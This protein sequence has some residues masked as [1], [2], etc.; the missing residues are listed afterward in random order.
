M[1]GTQAFL[2]GQVQFAKPGLE[3]VQTGTGFLTF[4]AE[5][6][7]EL[8]ILFGEPDLELD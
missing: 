7:Q 2:T 3:L 4:D 6:G 1:E 8:A 5:P